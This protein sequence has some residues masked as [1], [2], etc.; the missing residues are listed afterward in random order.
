VITY[1][2][3]RRQPA[4]RISRGLSA[5]TSA[6]WIE[7]AACPS[8]TRWLQLFVVQGSSSPFFPAGSG[9]PAAALDDDDSW[10]LQVF[11][12]L[13]QAVAFLCVAL[14]VYDINDVLRRSQGGF[15]LVEGGGGVSGKM[16]PPVFFNDGS[17][18]FKHA[19]LERLV[20]AS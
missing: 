17:G 5:V 8:V 11:G 3:D 7:A 14:I 1:L 4:P 10:G 13:C 19:V 18:N 9:T 12:S 15:D 16:R 6:L 2:S 20:Y